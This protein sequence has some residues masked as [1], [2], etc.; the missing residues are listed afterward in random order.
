MISKKDILKYKHVGGIAVGLMAAVAILLSQSF[1]FDYV[2]GVES[3]VKTEIPSS[4]QD[5][6]QTVIK[7]GQ[8]AV[9]SVATFAVQNVL[10]FITEIYSEDKSE[11]PSIFQNTTGFSSYLQN[12]FRLIISPNAP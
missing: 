3:N 12:L 5:E 6:Q 7:M 2:R 9:S 4:D 11:K 1:Y 8:Q 10:H